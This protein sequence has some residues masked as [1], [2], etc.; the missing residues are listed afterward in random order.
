[1]NCYDIGMAKGCG[2]LCLM[3]E[4]GFE[5]LIFGILGQQE[6]QGNLAIELGVLGK[7]DLAHTTGTDF[8]DDIVVGHDRAG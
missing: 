4:P 1:M 8:L 7:I 3:D 6:L 5:F 2:S